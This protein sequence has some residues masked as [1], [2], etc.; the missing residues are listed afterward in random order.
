MGI[1][2]SDLQ[3]IEQ[4]LGREPRGLQAV[5]VRDKEGAPMVVR[6]ASLV[7]GK[8]F[9]TMFWLIDKRVNY[10][11][12]QVE[13]RGL[14]AQLQEEVDAS[15]E[16][17]AD[18]EKD[19]QTHIYQRLSYMSDEDKAEIE[20]LGFMGVLS[21]R[22]IG[23]I[24]DF[25]RIRCLHTYYASHLVESNTVGKLLDSYW[26]EAGIVFPHFDFG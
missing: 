3:C 22:G 21:T 24:A 2:V 20:E 11:I 13:S 7:E 12:D 19:H 10:A 17:Q 16:W 14:I 9:P 6:V 25:H 26:R 5:V 1:S 8:P 18:M 4:L 23:G 15:S